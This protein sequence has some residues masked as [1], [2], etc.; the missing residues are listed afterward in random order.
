MVVPSVT[1]SGNTT[2][3]ICSFSII[4]SAQ[5][6]VGPTAVTSPNSSGACTL[7]MTAPTTVG[8]YQVVATVSSVGGATTSVEGVFAVATSVAPTPTPIPTP[9]P[10]PGPTPVATPKP[11]PIPTPVQTAKWYYFFETAPAGSLKTDLGVGGGIATYLTSSGTACSTVGDYYTTSITFR[12][13]LT[14][15]L[16]CMDSTGAGYCPASVASGGETCNL[17]TAPSGS[18]LEGKCT[19]SGQTCEAGC[20][21]GVW[22]VNTPCP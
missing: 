6:P 20:S 1:V 2:N 9:V 3:V 18:Y 7:T 11:T 16:V 17:T 21:S 15:Y 10:T 12:A 22:T 5:E 14:Y 13:T 8:N 4:N 19:V